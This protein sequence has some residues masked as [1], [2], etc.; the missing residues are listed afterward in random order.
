MKKQHFQEKK[1]FHCILESE[2]LSFKYIKIY[3]RV[4]PL[5][6]SNPSSADLYNQL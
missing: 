5:S 4:A 3:L 2:N 6:L 1:S